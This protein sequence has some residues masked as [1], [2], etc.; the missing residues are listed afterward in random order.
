M[1]LVAVS[2]FWIHDLRQVGPFSFIHALSV[3]TLISLF[4]GI[5]DIRRG[6]V[7]AHQKTMRQIFYIALIGAGAFTLLPGRDMH[8]VVFGQ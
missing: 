1:C 5:R 8:L 3:Y 4:Y 6:D 7:A 2:S